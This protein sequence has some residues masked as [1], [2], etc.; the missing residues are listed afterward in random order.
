MRTIPVFLMANSIHAKRSDCKSAPPILKPVFL[1]N[2]PNMF[3]SL[4]YF[5]IYFPTSVL[6]YVRNTTVFINPYVT[7]I[8]SKVKANRLK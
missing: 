6:F 1:T 8:S 4:Y 3:F 7:N 2:S 5:L